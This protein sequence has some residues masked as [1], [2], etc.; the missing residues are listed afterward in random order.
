VLQ[1][2]ST[3]VQLLLSSCCHIHTSTA[4]PLPL[5]LP[6]TPRHPRIAVSIAARAPR[7]LGKLPSESGQTCLIAAQLVNP[8]LDTARP[9]SERPS[10]SSLDRDYGVLHRAT[11]PKSAQHRS[12]L[13]PPRSVGEWASGR[14]G[15][16]GAPANRQ[17]SHFGPTLVFLPH[18]F[19][20]KCGFTV[21]PS[22]LRCYCNLRSRL[23]GVLAETMPCLLFPLCRV[24][25]SSPAVAHEPRASSFL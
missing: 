16:S 6:L 13:Q 24:A 21:V 22:G 19:D 23:F 25:R 11:V 4:I 7:F 20:C 2:E 14:T 15:A 9:N 8:N 1:L 10:S 3:H 17:P 12:S 18:C 5:P